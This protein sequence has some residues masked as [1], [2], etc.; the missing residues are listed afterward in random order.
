VTNKDESALRAKINEVRIL[1]GLG[2]RSTG[3]SMLGSDPERHLHRRT[4]KLRRC[5][6]GAG[7]LTL[8]PGVVAIA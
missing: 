5:T 2:I 1:D 7:L 6:S 3:V 4:K 8:S